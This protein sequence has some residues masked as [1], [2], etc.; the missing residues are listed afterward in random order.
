MSDYPIIALRK[1]DKRLYRQIEAFLKDAGISFDHNLD[2]TCVMLDAENNVIATGSCYGN[3][4]RC[5]AVQISHQG[6]NLLGDIISHLIENRF[7]KGITHLFVYTKINAAGLLKYLG[8]YEITRVE[9]TMV[10]MENRPHGFSSWLD[11]LPEAETD[12]AAIVMNANP[13]TNGHLYLLENAA[14][15]FPLVHLFLVSE[16]KSVFPYCIR[17]ELVQ[18]SISHLENVILHDCGPYMISQATFPSYFLKDENDVIQSHAALDVNI[19]IRIAE[20]LHIKARYVGE[21]PFSPTTA[22]Y[23]ETMLRLL[24]PHHIECHIIPRLK[25]DGIAVSASAVR[26]ALANNDIETVKKLVPSPVYTY[27]SS[28]DIKEI[29]QNAL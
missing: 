23:N 6:E 16:D 5:L 29:L 8:F 27:L 20:K 18:K 10:F 17:R 24:P 12:S 13:F 21:E 11:H 2:Y 28:I 3:T 9:N 25:I 7:E 1:N 26:K 22:L 14:A 4:L 19:F 15:S